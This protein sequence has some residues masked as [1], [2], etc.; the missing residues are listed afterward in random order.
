MEEY[1]V[2]RLS[3]L[4]KRSVEQN[5]SGI[6]LKAEV[7]ALKIPSSGHL[8][9]TLKDADA[10]IDAV[11][12]KGVAQRQK[13][14]LEDGMEVRC[15][16]RVTTYQLHSKYQFMV[17]EFELAGIGELLKL[18]EERRKKLADEGLFD[19]SR[20][21]PLP[22][23]P[24]LIGIITSSTG[25]VIKDM[26]HRIG[27]RF[28]REI[29][30]WPV[31]VQ[32]SEAA[33]QI[34]DAIR[35]MN[36]LPPDKRPD[37]LIVAR[38]G[39]SFEDLMPFNEESVVRATA[40]SQIPIISAVGHETDTTLIDYAADLRAP[41]P[42]A[43]AEFAVPERI[44]LRANVAKVFS[45]LTLLISNNLEKKKLFLRSN[46]ILNIESVVSERIQR[47]DYVFDRMGSGI[48]N[49]ISWKSV[50]LAKIILPKPMIQKNVDGIFQKLAFLF[51]AQFENAKNL[52]ALAASGI[53]SN[54]CAN[55]LK[56]GF[57]FVE[58]NKSLPITS[59]K[60]A[61]KHSNFDLVFSDGRLQVSPKAF[62]KKLFTD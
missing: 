38:G 22:E 29:L 37:L 2:S 58:S 46:R 49:K 14:K 45:Q 25:A 4:I 28:P 16:G 42:T 13:I 5:F 7:S 20:K 24:K 17:E 55:I 36:A 10:V 6:R 48:K 12:W 41:T 8:Y 26:L 50:L 56:K 62:Q 23:I 54:S 1:T 33:R 59:V 61:E 35:G 30:L 3:A 27:Q 43:A 18:L 39:G 21:K 19:A 57:A 34:V 60:E 53:E 47:A 32:G 51:I 31:L 44:M 11:C 40:E 9:F 15:L 52:L